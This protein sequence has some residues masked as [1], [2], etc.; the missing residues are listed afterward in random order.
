MILFGPKPINC[1]NQQYLE[2]LQKNGVTSIGS[3]C[4]L[5]CGCKTE[6]MAGI[7]WIKNPF[8][9]F[10]LIL[11]NEPLTRQSDILTNIDLTLGHLVGIQNTILIIH[12][13]LGPLSNVSMPVVSLVC[14]PDNLAFGV[15]PNSPINLMHCSNALALMFTNGL[16]AAVLPSLCQIM[17]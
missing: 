16:M 8:P 15:N 3:F 12:A 9:I 6:Y 5:E 14:F 11:V 1:T 13:A 10:I 17:S 2:W 7:I 4:V